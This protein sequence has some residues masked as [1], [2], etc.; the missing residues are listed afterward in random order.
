MLFRIS[1]TDNAAKNVF[2]KAIEQKTCIAFLYLNRNS[3]I[4]LPLSQV[5]ISTM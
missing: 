4:P 3:N 5:P 1:P 2:W